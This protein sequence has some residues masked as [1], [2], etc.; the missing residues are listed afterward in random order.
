[1]QTEESKSETIKQ[2]IAEIRRLKQQLAEQE[3]PVNEPIAVI[4]MACRFP[5]GITS[6][7][8]FWEVLVQMED[9]LNPV[10]DSRWS[11]YRDRTP[12]SSFTKKAGFLLE[13]IDAFDH[14]LFRFSP[15]EAERTDPQ[16]RLFL[17]VCWEAMEN[18]GYA[19]N[20]L[21]GSNT[22]VYSGISMTD[23]IQ[24]LYMSQRSSSTLEPCDVAG[25][26]F[27]FLTGRAAYF[28]GFQGPSITVDTACSSSLVA[29][30]QACKGLMAGDCEMAIAGGV[31]V[32]YS[33]ETTEL[34]SKLHILSPDCTIRSFDARANGTVRGEGC[35]VVVLK[36][37]SAAVR[38]G[39]HIHAVIRGSGVNQDGLSSG[40]TA[41]YG[42]AQ[43]KL[44]QGVWKRSGLGSDDIGFIEAHGTGTELGDPIEM[45]ALGNIVAHRRETSLYVGT[46]KTNIGHLEAA[47]GI[48]G[49]I[50]AILAVERGKIPGNLHFTDPSPHID[51]DRI[52]IQVPT[53]T[54]PWDNATGKPRTAGVSSFGLS[55]SNAHVVVEQYMASAVSKRNEGNSGLNSGENGP[56]PTHNPLPFKFSSV[57]ESGL[58]DQLDAMLD[59]LNTERVRDVNIA[60]LSYSLNIAKA[61]LQERLV[62]W[63]QSADDLKAKLTGVLAGEP[64]RSVVYGQSGKAVVFLLTGQGS[65]YPGMFCDLY[66]DNPVFKSSMDRCSEYYRQLTGVHLTD[67]IFSSQPL[68][69]ETRYTQPALFAVE[70]SLVQMWK[71]FGVVPEWMIG[72]SVGEYAAACEAGVFSLADAMKLITA[73]GELMGA[74]PKVGKMAA[75]MADKATVMSAMKDKKRVSIAATNYAEQ[76]VISGDD[77][78]VVQVCETLGAAGI[79]CVSLNVSHAFH[80]PLMEPMIARFEAVAR[81]VNYFAPKKTIVSTVTGEPIGEDI[82]CWQYW[83]RHIAA[84][85]K[86]YDAIRRVEVPEQYVFLEIGPSPILTGMVERIFGDATDVVSSNDHGGQAMTRIER[87][88]FHLYT[89]GVAV[90][91]KRYYA[92]AQR[93]KVPVPT[94]RF[95]EKWFRLSGIDDEGFISLTERTGPTGL[96]A[97]RPVDKSFADWSEAKAFV[98]AALNRELLTEEDELADDQN[99]LLHGLNSIVTAKLAALWRNELSVPVAPVDLLQNCTINQWA[100]ILYALTQGR[101]MR[102][103]DSGQSAAF[104]PMPE[105][106]YEPFRL[107][108][109]Q[110]A[111][112]VGRNPELDL[113][114]VSCYASLEIDI[115]SLDPDRFRHALSALVRR[116]DML[117]CIISADGTQCIMPDTDFIVPLTVYRRESIDNLQAHLESVRTAMS[118]LVIPFGQPMYDIRLTEMDGAQWRIHFGIDFMIADALSLMIF[119]NDLHEIYNGASLPALEVTFRDYLQYTLDRKTN[120][121]YEQDKQYWT[122]RAGDFPSA[123][124]LPVKLS[125]TSGVR[126]GTFSRRKK[127]LDPETW[128]RFARTAAERKLTP[129]AA[130]LALYSEVLSAWG[131]GSRFAVMLTVFNRDAVHPEID[132]VIGDFTELMLVDVRREETSAGTNAAA[133]QT[134]MLA[135]MEHSQYSAVEF[136]K[137]LNRTDRLQ[138]R[139]YPV[140][141]T[142]ALGMDQRHGSRPGDSWLD[143]VGWAVSTTPQVWIDHQAYPEKGGV[144]LSWD[145]LDAIFHPNVVDA[146][147]DQYVELVLRAAHEPGF[148][149]ETLTDVR[150]Q[151]QEENHRQVNRTAMEMPGPW[152]LHERIWDWSR[153]DPARTAIIVA[154]KRYSFGQL[155]GRAD[156]VAELLQA[157]GVRQGDRVVLQ[158]EKSFEQLAIVL[159]IVQI[160]AAYVPLSCDQPVSRVLD[161]V[162][163]SNSS[164]I[165]VD[166]RLES[167]IDVK[168][169]TASDLDELD[170]NYRM[171]DVYP[172]D[173]AYVIYTSGSTGTPKGVCIEHGAAMNT[174]EDVNN[175][176]SLTEEDCIFGVS[177]LHFDLS[178]YDIFGALGAGAALV[179]PTEAQRLD[180]R[181]WAELSRKYGITV[182]NS[183]PALMEL[184]ADYLLRGDHAGANTDPKVRQVALSGDWIPL[185]LHEK[186]KRALPNASLISMGGATEASIWS[187]YYEVSEI[188]P[189]WTSIPYGYPLANQKFYVLDEFGRPCPDWVQGRL[190]IAGNGLARG[191]LNDDERT[192]KAFR[193][194]PGLVERLYDT[195]D[196]GRYMGD[197]AIEFLGR[198]DNQV[199]INGY[200]IEIGEIQAAF[201]K[202]GLCDDAVIIPVGGRMESKK[203]MAFVAG[204]LAGI[205]ETEIKK[206][207]RLHLPGYCIPDKIV[208]VERFPLTANGKIDRKALLERIETTEASGKALAVAGCDQET[209]LVLQT[210]RDTLNLPEL[211]PDDH[212]GDLGVSSVDMIRL[213]NHL[214]IVYVDR[215]TIGEMMSYESVSGLLLFYREKRVGA[216]GMPEATSLPDSKSVTIDP[217]QAEDWN[218]FEPTE[219]IVVHQPVGYKPDVPP[220]SLAEMEKRRKLT[221]ACKAQGIQ[222]YVEDDRLKFKAPSGAMS[223]DVQAELKANKESL[224]HYIREN[225]GSLDTSY[226]LPA[227]RPF[228]LTPI[229]LAYV[230]GRSP[231][232][233]LGNVS[234]HYYAEFDCGKI[235]VEQLQIAVNETI[236]NNEMLRTVVYANGTQRVFQEVP[237][238]CIPVHEISDP[239]MLERTRNEWSHRHFELGKWPMF[240]IQLSRLSDSSSRLHFSF[241]CLIVDGWSAELMFRTIFRA[242]YGESVPQPGF[243]FREYLAMEEKWLKEKSNLKEAETYWDKH[244]MTLPPAPSLPLKR[245]FG[246][247]AAPRFGRLVF[248]LTEE[249]T[250]RINDKIKKYRFTPSAVIC[251]AF[252]KVLSDRSA[253]RDI[254][255]NLTLFNRLPLHHDVPHV[256][257]DFTNITLISYFDHT[258][259]TFTSEVEAIQEQLW[260]AV[261]YRV[262]NGLQLLRKLSQDNP[263]GAVMPVVFT[264]LLFG[265]SSGTDESDLPPDI[266]EGYAISQTS[267]VALDHQAYVRNGKMSLVWDYVEDVFDDGTIEEMFAQYRQFVERL[268]EQ[269]DWN[270]P[271][272]ATLMQAVN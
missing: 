231:D 67:L 19:P 250:S 167:P 47:A 213:A 107:N 181:C 257:G 129:S 232:Y 115:A 162:R 193:L 218:Y 202:C 33:P 154:D 199:K 201:G 46:V 40:L 249:Q 221:E 164:V 169:F 205:S 234:A 245:G 41:P 5:G 166:H 66:N 93:N 76:T 173:L 179:L 227:S 118:A 168:Q 183:V 84:E 35:G 12:D 125:G 217:E 191:Y 75:V 42:P 13:D 239:G 10:P 140:V 63:A 57:T 149:L 59:Y 266:Q 147:F 120:G 30:D 96:A 158:M 58:Y 139:T 242:Y 61:D 45:N 141:F 223:P 138:E 255:L 262:Y 145:T 3:R 165:F 206:R 39:D 122:E 196:Y 123:P 204:D 186:I 87:S 243:T 175:R 209:D 222:L 146:M 81:E 228:R 106:R 89:R 43:E 246:D 143:N 108:D 15:K 180:P 36:K 51:W 187:N 170:G 155:T 177:A 114:G 188:D 261:E 270:Q 136:V 23:Y 161:I 133:I 176:L 79:R 60:D 80:S 85:V 73:R 182:W 69:H 52:A 185:D 38:D 189:A 259:A 135:D 49:L 132:R 195:G 153:R 174:I 198:A 116:H 50:K 248:T 94:Y 241:D 190:H 216:S 31:N 21:R 113:G 62:V 64:D 17:K 247:V 236:R 2:A 34:L 117:R 194:H 37:L 215:P 86:F 211:G 53:A 29:V 74:L 192:N 103:T 137:E 95:R 109:I 9:C 238:L 150:P 104:H 229:Q 171:V 219:F 131:G 212:F 148:W 14:R 88:L 90:E 269:E 112:W 82:A 97:A 26:G 256:L 8:R 172:S 260:K 92:G 70:Y 271:L 71:A 156:Q 72:H 134:Q 27:S 203:L 6:P 151:A 121:R 208:A 220:M 253:H 200:R 235:H 18:S 244:I 22:G 1:M 184:Y 11:H 111:Y 128:Q 226:V 142:S 130:L 100:D 32:M 272:F 258:K 252:M 126:Q 65:Q 91:W 178:V 152:L 251:T 264:S 224:I 254:T 124:A 55:G 54:M 78:E 210:I 20:R 230:L 267:Q 68:V 225:G 263:G 214:E 237:E 207:L 7:E 110:Y 265:D 144:A 127:W 16:Q 28:F 77:E 233:E 44:I 24:Q 160:G 101:E 25:S 157:H 105:H 98:R 240:H 159:G 163:M 56:L 197:G 99:L 83:S 268:I 102:Q 48:A 4:G 119:W